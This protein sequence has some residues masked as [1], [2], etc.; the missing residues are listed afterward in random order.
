M[1]RVIARG[2][3]VAPCEDP[4]ALWYDLES[5]TEAEEAEVEQELGIDVP[6]PDERAAFEESA[7]YY[8]EGESLHLTATLLGRREEGAFK[9]GP[10][11]FILTKGRLVTVRQVRPRAFEIGH[12]R[13]SARISSSQTG[14]DVLLALIEGAA[15]RHAD[16]LQEAMRDANALA[17]KMF[18]NTD[19]DLRA[20]LREL[21]RISTIAALAHDS[22]SS[23]QRLL[24]YARA[25][26]GRY[27][28]EDKRIS[29][30]ARDVNELERIA[31]AMQPRL[32]YLQD[33]VLGLINAAQTNVLKALSLAT[34]AFVPATLIASIFGMNFDALTW[35]RADWGPAVAFALM[36]VAPAGLFVIAKWRRWF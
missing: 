12:G 11:T 21:A 7:R 4:A 33:A 28:L 27:G 29:A 22:L 15:E 19:A 8:E 6:T 31:E 30:L 35:F 34:I 25:T 13:A 36:I 9:S 18:D 23:M 16:I 32:S 2:G 10:V 24:V 3:I 26:K 14:A 20:G 5:P 1:L 17:Q